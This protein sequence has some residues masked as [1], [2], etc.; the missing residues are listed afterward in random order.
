MSENSNTSIDLSE[1]FTALM[2]FTALMKGYQLTVERKW[3]RTLKK[4]SAYKVD[5]CIS[6]DSE[7]T[8]TM[9]IVQVSINIPCYILWRSH[10]CL[11]NEM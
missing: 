10:V 1:D 2:N 4:I 3:L 8:H 6:S 11:K 9:V 7:I 5:K